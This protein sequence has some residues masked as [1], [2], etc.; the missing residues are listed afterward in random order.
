MSLRDAA[1]T[2]IHQ[3]L[4]LQADE[5]CVVVTD[6]ERQPIG[7]ALYEVAG[8]VT[9]DAAI[10][11]YPP[12]PQHGAEPPAP[13]AAA[14]R[15]A[16]VF[17]APTTK[18]LSH[19]T[20]RKDACEAGARGATLPGITE[21]VFTTGLDADYASI[22]AECDRVL[23]VDAP[24][25]VQIERLIQRDGGDAASARAILER[26]SPRWTRL[27]RADDVIDNAD[28]VAPRTA[29]DPQVRGLDRK[30]RL[31]AQ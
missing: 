1:E 23:V 11:R 21:D 26:Q 2:A 16:D 20:A 4:A 25:A 7:E 15:G 14:M 13:V 8:E 17:L 31:L 28:D 18:S 6:D 9:D 29:L 3:C 22:A 24:E 5:S 10:V 27:Q 30:Y 12:G 19:T